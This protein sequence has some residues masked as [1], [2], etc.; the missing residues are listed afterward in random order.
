[1][2]TLNDFPCA[3][4][5]NLSQRIFDYVVNVRKFLMNFSNNETYDYFAK[6]VSDAT[7]RLLMTRDE[8]DAAKDFS[9]FLHNVRLS[10][11]NL[12]VI[13][14]EMKIASELLQKGK[15][16][17]EAKT[18][19]NETEELKKIFKQLKMKCEE[20][21]ILSETPNIIPRLGLFSFLIFVGSFFL[22]LITEITLFGYVSMFFL[23]VA[24]YRAQK[25]LL[26]WDEDKL[27]ARERI[28]E[29]RKKDAE[30]I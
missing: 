15:N 17:N 1:M 16:F 28:L 5:D 27:A 9:E 21:K 23:I 13:E 6:T 26:I 4:D 2:N 30:K 14:N 20:E 3:I 11:E 12:S 19:L 7:R 10:F 22:F 8:I 24:L 29:K 18:I 25:R